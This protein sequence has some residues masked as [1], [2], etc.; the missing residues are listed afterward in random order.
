MNQSMSVLVVIGEL[1]RRCRIRDH[2]SRQGLNVYSTGSAQT[3]LDWLARHRADAIVADCLLPGT[4]IAMPHVLQR[5]QRERAL[6]VGLVA[7]PL[8]V[9]ERLR[10]L[11]GYDELLPSA[12]P[13]AVLTR[14]VL[15]GARKV[16]AAG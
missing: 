14:R 11:L 9:S 7:E 3:A 8:T 15:Q 13:A 4:R 1:E 16:A 12:T 10:E 2:L 6:L 5:A